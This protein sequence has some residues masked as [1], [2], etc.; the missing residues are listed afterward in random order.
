MNRRRALAKR[1]RLAARGP[2]Q[3]P[4]RRWTTLI[5]SGYT[6]W[7]R[8]TMDPWTVVHG[9]VHG[10]VSAA[11]VVHHAMND[12]DP[13]PAPVKHAWSPLLCK[14]APVLPKIT[15]ITFHLQESLRLSPDSYV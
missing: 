9:A 14:K 13:A 2:P 6:P 7:P 10:H 3:P 11:P 1:R 15:T 8:S 12:G 5:R 4:D